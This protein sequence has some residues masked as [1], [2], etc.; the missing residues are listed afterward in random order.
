MVGEKHEATT[1]PYLGESEMTLER[2]REAFGQ[3]HTDGWPLQYLSFTVMDTVWVPS[4]TIDLECVG[5]HVTAGMDHH[6][7]G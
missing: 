4:F 5:Y 3:L 6:D 2:A 1:G 7:A